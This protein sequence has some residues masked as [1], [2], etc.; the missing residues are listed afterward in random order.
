VSNA[1]VSI[2][3]AKEPASWHESAPARDLNGAG[4]AQRR[5][6][7]HWQ[8]RRRVRRSAWAASALL[9]VT[10]ASRAWANGA[11]P[12][13]YGIL[14]PADKPQQIV[15]ATNFG[16]IIS[17]DAGAS[18]LW[19]CEQP[20]TS[21]G[22]LYGV[23]SAP[24][25]RFYALSPEQGLGFSDDGSCAWQRSGGVLAT[26]VASDF[27]IDRSNGD[28]LL[29][30][31]AAIDDT[32]G[33]GAPSIF[34]SA[35][36]GM[37]FASTPLY[38]A[39]A[40]ANIVSIEIA[41]SNPMVIYA[42]MYTTA[43]NH[44]RLLRSADGGQSWMDRDVQAGLGANQ[45][46]IL[47]VDPE[48]ADLLYLRVT[49]SGMDEVAVTRDAGATFAF[50][51]TVAGG[52]LSAF[53]RL[54]SGT[55]LVAGYTSLPSGATNGVAYRSTDRG[56]TFVPW[57]LDPQP[58]IFGLAERAGV[59]YLAGKNYSDGWALATSRDEGVTIQPL[60]SYEDV[61]GIKHCAMS[62][63]ADQCALVAMQAVWSNDV[64]TAV[65][66]PPP[67]KS[68]GCSCAAAGARRAS[69][70][71]GVATLIVVAA[72]VAVRRRRRRRRDG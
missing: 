32:G 42:A 34:A 26:L 61:R 64:C 49:A 33:F 15:L 10:I 6:A 67:P 31:A 16:M 18:W 65:P 66:P 72:G 57:T 41:R 35:D 17:E 39:P 46:R 37:T 28:R 5:R 60:S 71:A 44:P 14:L 1:I 69:S 45:F 51:V 40:G 8:P 12:A 68:S 62:I 25:D 36:G 43:D 52:A 3:A 13:S 59:L 29:A 48:D 2:G 21:F 53:A 50:P 63:C 56:H 54:A 9:V 19:T 47:A 20:Q 30:V 70:R 38:V 24:R 27:F 23:G 4:G 55:V 22:Y 7:R 11:L 58:H